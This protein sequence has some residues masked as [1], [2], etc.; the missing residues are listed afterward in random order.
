M[1]QALISQKQRLKREIKVKEMISIEHTTFL[2]GWGTVISE[3][4]CNTS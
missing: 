3:K 4:S 1:Q 2:V